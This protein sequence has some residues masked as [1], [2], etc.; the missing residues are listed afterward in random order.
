M[1][2]DGD[3]PPAPPA[4]LTHEERGHRIALIIIGVSVFVAIALYWIFPSIFSKHFPG[5]RVQ[6]TTAAS[7]APAVAPGDHVLVNYLI[8]DISE[9][10]RGDVVVAEV[11]EGG[12]QI[13][14]FKRIVAI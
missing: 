2:L 7:M 11:N 8:Y 12:K 14:M 1:L 5:F 10:K 6:N 9:P 3:K 4:P 13:L